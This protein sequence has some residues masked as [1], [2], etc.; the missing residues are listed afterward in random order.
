VLLDRLE[1]LLPVDKK[2]SITRQREW[3]KSAASLSR[4][5]KVI[6][7]NLLADSGFEI[8][9][10]RAS[11]EE[12]IKK[13]NIAKG[14]S[15]V[16]IRKI[17]SL[18]SLPHYVRDSDQYGG[19]SNEDIS[20]VIQKSE[21]THKISSLQ[22]TQEPDLKQDSEASDA[23]SRASSAVNQNDPAIS[24]IFCDYKDPIESD[25]VKHYLCKHEPDLSKQPIVADT[26]EERAICLV[27]WIRTRESNRKRKNMNNQDL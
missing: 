18:S 16:K 7:S 9:F 27:R 4:K 22:K 14:T 20:E 2:D 15:L 13:H 6:N 8:E 24:C 11:T 23:I 21:D 26:M 10:R 19:K 25:L 5:L 12:D 17:A 3:P 1:L